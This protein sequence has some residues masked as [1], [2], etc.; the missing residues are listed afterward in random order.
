MYTD[1][2]VKYI[3]GE[4]DI[5]V[6]FMGSYKYQFGKYHKDHPRFMGE[7]PK[8][9]YMNE[10]EKIYDLAGVLEKLRLLYP[11]YHI[12]YDDINEVIH[13]RVIA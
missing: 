3:A 11:H 5:T 12:F 9:L 7:V 10:Y 13:V 2:L 4:V 6:P 1:A 8:T